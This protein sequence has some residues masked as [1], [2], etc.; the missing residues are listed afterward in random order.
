MDVYARIG[1]RPVIN[2]TCHWT[3]YGGTVMWPE[4]VEAMAEARQ[5]CVDMRRLLD[6]A[7]EVIGRHTHAEAGHVVSGCAAGLQAGAAAIMTG[8][9]PAKMAA[10]PHTAGEM[11]NEFI[12]RRFG[13][14]RTADGREYVQ[15]GYA[16]AVSGAGGVFVEVGDER[17]ATRQEFEAAFG[18]G[19]AGVYWVSDG[20]EPG[21]QL[22]EVINVAHARGVPV[23]V[24]ASNTLPPAEHLH[25][26][27]DMGADLVAFSG[28]KGLRGPQGSGILAG[29]ADLIRAARAQSAPVHGIG[30][31]LKVSKEEVVGLLTALELWAKRDHAADLR[32]ARR[33]T[34]RVVEALSGL[35][36]IRAEHRFPDHRGRPYPTVFI[37]IDPTTG[38]TGARVIEQLLAGDPSVAIM[39]FDD[40]QIVRADVRIL[41]DDEVEIVA[42]RLLA[43]LSRG[44]VTV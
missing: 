38:L 39:S 30:R 12:A 37:H 15:R 1:V 10:L 6:R 26:F 23:L 31:P 2:A 41:A 42:A 25:R 34:E 33:R 7:G 9:D 20:L 27:I 4:V 14:R 5:A 40:P 29:R 18:S 19:T 17:G 21:I 24:D 35:P 13:R 32:D 22:D 44:M 11:K 28:G 3:V 43:V 16:Q 36:G 8:D